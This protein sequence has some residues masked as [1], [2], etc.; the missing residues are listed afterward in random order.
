[1]NNNKAFKGY[2]IRN[3][4]PGGDKVVYKVFKGTVYNSI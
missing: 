1:M 2:L 4:I 3:G